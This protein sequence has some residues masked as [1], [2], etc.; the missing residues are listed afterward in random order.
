MFSRTLE[1]L[2]DVADDGSEH[3]LVLVAVE[4]AELGD[5]GEEGD[6]ALDDELGQL[7]LGPEIVEDIVP[8]VDPALELQDGRGPADQLGDGRRGQQL[9]VRRVASLQQPL[10]LS[11]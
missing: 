2:G 8:D 5:P 11:L 7:G 3:E 4:P 10:A 9:G 6:Q 1:E